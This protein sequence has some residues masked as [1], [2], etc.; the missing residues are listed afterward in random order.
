MFQTVNGH[1]SRAVP[2]ECVSKLFCCSKESCRQFHPAGFVGFFFHNLP[3]KWTLC[4]KTAIVILFNFDHF[5]VPCVLISVCI[6]GANALSNFHS[7]QHHPL[8][9]WWTSLDMYSQWQFTCCVVGPTYCLFIIVFQAFFLNL[10]FSMCA[11]E[12]FGISNEIKLLQFRMWKTHSHCYPGDFWPWFGR[13]E[14]K[15]AVLSRIPWRWENEKI[16]SSEHGLCL[17]PAHPDT[18]LRAGGSLIYFLFHWGLSLRKK[19]DEF[20]DVVLPCLLSAF[21]FPM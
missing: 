10:I 13:T 6:N 4:L 18:A 15:A 11:L 8:Q 17:L 2:F 20:S 14:M 7:D 16:P 5:W 19:S 1:S 3:M 12:K 21:A 9:V